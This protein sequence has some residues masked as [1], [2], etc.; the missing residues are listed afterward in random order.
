[1]ATIQEVMMSL[2]T[3]FKPEKAKG[4]NRV[5]LFDLVGEE[6]SKWTL[7]IHDGVATVTEG[8]TESPKLVISGN[9]E[10]LVQMFT[11]EVS[12]MKLVNAKLVKMKGPM[13]D[14]IA[15]SGLWNIPKK[16]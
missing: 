9:S 13:M 7:K 8:E 2:P 5:I 15:F 1:M 6:P 3:I 16:G 12:P 10:H 4:W 11:G 14:S